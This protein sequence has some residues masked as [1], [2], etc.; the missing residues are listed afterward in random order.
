VAASSSSRRP[1]ARRQ[2]PG[3]SS[4]LLVGFAALVTLVFIVGGLT[5]NRFI[6][7]LVR[8]LAIVF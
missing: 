1:T 7:D 4:L 8:D 2:H 3:L 5:E 6:I